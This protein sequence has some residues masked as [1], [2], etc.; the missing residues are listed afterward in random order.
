MR[1]G[2]RCLDCDILLKMSDGVFCCMECIMKK[3][4]EPED[5]E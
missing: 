5:A 1:N 2:E 4:T 3:A